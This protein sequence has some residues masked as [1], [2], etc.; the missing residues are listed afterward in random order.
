MTISKAA[1]IE[2]K[3]SSV[4]QLIELGQDKGYLLFD[5]IYE[6]LPEEVVAVPD[7]L[8]AV[9]GR[10]SDLDIYVIDRPE[11]HQ[12]RGEGALPGVDFDKKD[13]EGA[14]EHLQREGDSSDQEGYGRGGP[15]QRVAPGQYRERHEAQRH[16]AR[17]CILYS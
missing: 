11:R 6:M 7:D 16:A 3:Y 1:S 9:Y 4:K 8:A 14:Q 17:C 13:G 5:E 15:R 10:L 12:N 2:K